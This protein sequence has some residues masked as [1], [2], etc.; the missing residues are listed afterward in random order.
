MNKLPAPPKNCPQCDVMW[1][2][3]NEHN[4][5][6][7]AECDLH[8]SDMNKPEPRQWKHCEY[9]GHDMEIDGTCENCAITREMQDEFNDWGWR[10]E[11]EKMERDRL[12]RQDYDDLHDDLLNMWDEDEE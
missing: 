9:C 8:W 10:L 6:Y 2:M 3:I 5:A 7:C 1:S 11:Q 12:T 4:N